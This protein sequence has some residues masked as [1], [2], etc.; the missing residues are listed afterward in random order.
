MNSLSG[1][2]VPETDNKPGSE[3]KKLPPATTPRSKLE[4]RLMRADS[5]CSRLDL[6]TYKAG[7]D[8][9]FKLS[10][11]PSK[12]FDVHCKWKGGKPYA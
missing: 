7:M 1:G 11:L 2:S 9:D 6:S 8:C 5:S 3:M 10:D 12:V 4:R